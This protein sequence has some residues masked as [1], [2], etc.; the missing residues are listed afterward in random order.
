MNSSLLR[1]IARSLVLSLRLAL[2]ALMIH[3]AV[4][5]I[6]LTVTPNLITNDYAGKLTITVSGLTPGQTV[7]VEKIGDL[8]ANGVVNAGEPL[9]QSSRITDGV[10]PSIGGVRNLNVPGDEDGAANGQMRIELNYP[11]TESGLDGIAGKYLVRVSA[12]A[13]GLAPVTSP[14]EIRQKVFAQGVK[15]RITALGT[16]IPLANAPVVLLP[17]ESNPVTGTFTDATGNYT[18]YAPPGTYTV[19]PLAPG[20]VAD[21]SGQVTLN[22]GPLATVDL[23]LPAATRTISGKVKDGVSGAGIPGV[24][25]QA[26]SDSGQFVGAFS[27]GDGTYSVGVL[28]DAWEVTPSS[29]SLMQAGYLGWQNGTPANAVGD[30]VANLDLPVDAATALIYGTMKDRQGNPVAGIHLYSDDQANQYDVWGARSLPPN[31]DYCLGVR[32]G[33]WWVGPDSDA[34]AALGYTGQGTSVTVTASQALRLDF[35]LGRATARLIG[36]VLD[37]LG[38]PVADIGIYADDSQGSHVSTTTDASGNFD[39][40]VFGGTWRLNIPYEDAQPRDLLTTDLTLTV[41]DGETLRDIT[42]VAQRAT[43]HLRGRLVDNT[44]AGVGNLQ[45]GAYNS[46]QSLWLWTRTAA[47]GDFDVGVMA[48]SWSLQLNQDEA[49]ARN[50]IG[51]SSETLTVVNGVDQNNLVVIAQRATAQISGW[52]R[53]AGAEPVAN[54]FI[55]SSANRNGIRYDLYAVTDGNGNYQLG[56]FD[57]EWQLELNCGGDRSLQSL[58]YLCVDP[59]QINVAGA[60]VTRNIV[61]QSATAPQITTDSLPGA[62]VGSFYS[63]QLQASGGQQPYVWSLSPGSSPLPAGLSL[64][65][66]GTLNGTPG[67]AGTFSF[68]VRVT[69]AGPQSVADRAL[70]LTVQPSSLPLQ[71][72]TGSLADG[73]VGTFYSQSLNATGGEPPY[74]WSLAPGSASLPPGLSLATDGTISGTPG[75]GGTFTFNVRVTDAQLATADGLLSIVIP[76]PPLQITTTSLPDAQLGESYSVQL[77]AAGGQAPYVWSVAPGSLGLPPNL[78]LSNSGLISGTP[79][80]DGTSFFIVRVTDANSSFV[81]R[82]LGLTINSRPTLTALTRSGNQFQLR[83]AG[84]IGQTYTVQFSDDPGSAVWLPLTTI[85]LSSASAII[86]DPGTTDTTRFYHAV[87]LP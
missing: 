66:D 26:Q 74:L 2:A 54:L 57:G 55:W 40:G 77:Q 63:A 72:A 8:N 68:S 33:S 64:G 38:A 58:G 22:A 73:T 17:P 16:G 23:A 48:G 69:G 45:M 79:T 13:G 19:L 3:R 14:L 52:V 61:V 80:S 53:N 27:G 44:G 78:N 25:I 1:T 83:L 76:N 46:S 37:N 39:L 47:N 82:S 34:L 81:N 84:A 70:S 21:F 12:P 29:G 28:A 75:T 87:P 50:L 31:A 59:A 71:V 4:G 10:R 42:F 20:H 49:R 51:P 85:T 7:L 32:P 65:N 6:V 35:T 36:R 30:N 24:F 18:L 9:L 60:S 67:T 5:G 41:A 56:V 11:G 62:T 43:A 86:T 15:G